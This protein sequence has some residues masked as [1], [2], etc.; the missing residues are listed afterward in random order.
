M[1]WNLKQITKLLPTFHRKPKSKPVALA[2]V[3]P[4]PNPSNLPPPKPA[5]PTTAIT[6]APAPPPA[7]PAKILLPRPKPH[8]LLDSVVNFL[9]Q[10]IATDDHL[11]N[12]LALW[13][14][15]TW[16]FQSSPTAVYLGISSPEPHCGKST[17]LRLLHM[18]SAEPWLATGPDARTVV[19]RLL[20]QECSLKSGKLPELHP[21]HVLLLDNHHHTLG[22]SER[23]GLL[24]MLSCGYSASAT[25]A[26]GNSEYCLFGPKVFAG[27]G[28]LPRSLADRCIPITLTRK[29]PSEVVARLNSDATQTATRVRRQLQEWA[30]EFRSALAQ[31]ARRTPSNLP[32]ALDL[33]QQNNSEPLLHIADLVGGT[34]P[35]R[36]RVSLNSIYKSIDLSTELLALDSVRCWFFVKENPEYILT[37]D[38]IASMRTQ[39]NRPWSGWPQNAGRRLG[40]LLHPFGIYSRNLNFPDGKTLKGYVFSDFKDAWERYLAPLPYKSV[41]ELPSGPTLGAEKP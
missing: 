12:I 5:T 17:C 15:H 33:L 19:G 20:T 13:I 31:A 7:N 21:P 29:R 11:L 25:Y 32:S 14:A 16:C 37:R 9:R 24:A 41:Q 30:D 22:R 23:Q 27:R 39:E 2:L 8:E 10:Y 1:K 34:W 26:F 3:K 4:S 28:P 6:Q 36:A 35:E 40:A 38:L 18:L